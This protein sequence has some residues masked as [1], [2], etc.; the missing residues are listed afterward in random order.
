MRWLPLIV[1]LV[2]CEGPAGPAGSPGTTG[3]EGP[4]GETGGS[5]APGQP[6]G[7]APW[8]TQPGVDV[9]VSQLAFAD[10]K[11][12]VRFTLTDGKGLGLDPTGKLTDGKVAVSFVLAQL[13]KN[14]DDSAGQYTAYTT[15]VQTSPITSASATQAA[16]ESNGTLHVIDAASGTYSY[17]IAAPLTGLVPSATQTV[18]VLA[19]RTTSAGQAFARTTFSARPDGGALATREVVTAGAC[20][21]CHRTLDAHG[22]RWTKPEQ[23]VLC[24]QPQSSDPDTGNTVDFKVMIHKLHRGASL[25]SVAVN[26]TPYQI[27]GFGQ[28]V[29]D[30]SSVVFPQEIERCTAC[31]AGAEGDHWKTAPSKTTCTSCHDT[32]SFDLPVPA[33]MVAHGGGAQPDNAKCPVCHPATG[34]LA[35]V[36]DK[37]LVGLVSDHAPQVALD[38]QSMTSTGPGQT[39]VMTF[40]ALVDGAPRDLLAQPLTSVTATIAG[41]NTDFASFWQAKMQGGG[42]VGTLTAVNAADGVFSYTFPASAAIPATASGSYTVGIEAYLQ[43]TPS[44]P[45]YAAESPVKPFAVTGSLQPRRQI[46]DGA[47]CNNCHRDLEGHGGSRKNP[48]YCVMCH[49]PNKTNDTRA[50]RFEG[51]SVVAQSVDFRVMIHKIHRGEGLSEPYTLFGFPVPSPAAPG[52]TPLD[53]TTV[54]YPRSI[55]E[56][57]ACHAAKNWTLPLSN[58]LAYLPSTQKT[59]TCSEPL[60][61]DADSFCTDPFWTA[62][63]PTTIPVT[64][65]VCTS[66]HDAPDVRAHAE[67]NTTP[68]GTE[69]CAT[70][71]GKGAA[72]DVGALHGLP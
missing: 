44:D 57:E 36:S 35:G 51:S 48:Q 40:R 56:C 72:Y 43:P 67:L 38:I 5:G 27:I 62:S 21:A 22:G 34:S 69:A 4:P 16:A 55:V 7:P 71:H 32:T 30:F 60:G 68:A 37:H 8:L 29:N 46:V 53:F 20:N 6:A 52:G 58:S 12:T 65:S 31:H 14:A 23:C 19:V 15:Q 47:L 10:G 54:R 45:R 11:A 39:P 18:G 61:N 41:P 66:C 42:A 50:P 3:P 28:R 64:T 63:P 1:L 17:D 33:G 49:N 59:L 70:C 25:P 2:A 9:Q 24:H 26:H 13:A